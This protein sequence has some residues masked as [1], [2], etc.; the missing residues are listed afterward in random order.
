LILFLYRA[1]IV[2]SADRDG[3]EGVVEAAPARGD[4]EADQAVPEVLEGRPEGGARRRPASRDP[5]RQQEIWVS[6]VT[7]NGEFSTFGR[8]K[9]DRSIPY[10]IITSYN[11]SNN[12]NKNNNNIAFK[13][14]AIFVRKKI[15]INETRDHEIDPGFQLISGASRI[16]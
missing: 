2:C 3:R 16:G 15:K 9:N 10:Y 8:L 12:N 5:R 1:A 7:K 4:R 6:K 11:N 14:K 13:K